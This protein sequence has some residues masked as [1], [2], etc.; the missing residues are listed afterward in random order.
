M[1]FVRRIVFTS[2]F[3]TPAPRVGLAES[4]ELF[5]A[6]LGDRRLQPALRYPGSAD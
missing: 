6:L 5:D 4:P 1:N 3:E 2:R